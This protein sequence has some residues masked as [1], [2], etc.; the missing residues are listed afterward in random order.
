MLAG[1]F[2]CLGYGYSCYATVTERPG[3]NGDMH[4]YYRLSIPQ[5]GSYT[6][7]ISFAALAIS[8]LVFIFL[9]RKR[10]RQLNKTL[11]AFLI[12]IF[13]LIACEIYLSYRFVGKG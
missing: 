10:A 6:F 13:V 4:S 12:F 5:F 1:G 7:A 3:L 11:I 8:F 2:V 9:L